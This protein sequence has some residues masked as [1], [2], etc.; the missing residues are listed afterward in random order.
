MKLK[1][2]RRPETAS[3]EAS[4]RN[5]RPR[6]SPAD[7]FLAQFALTYRCIFIVHVVLN[8]YQALPDLGVNYPEFR[9]L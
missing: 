2:T 1:G 4:R 6:Q 9:S 3:T 8:S 7:L 5:D